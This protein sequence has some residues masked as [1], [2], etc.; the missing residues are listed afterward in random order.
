MLSGG[1]SVQSCTSWR[2]ITSKPGSADCEAMPRTILHPLRFSTD[3]CDAQAALHNVASRSQR[4][5]ALGFPPA[6]AGIPKIIATR[7]DAFASGKVFK[8]EQKSSF[9]ALELPP[10]PN[11]LVMFCYATAA[12]R[13]F[14]ARHATADHCKIPNFDLEVTVRSGRRIWVDLSTLIF[15]DRRT[16]RRLIVHLSR[17]ITERKYSEDLL[18]KMLH[19]SKQIIAVTD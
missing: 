18:H 16:H 1:I 2:E 19:L 14:Y 12:T 11:W 17:D 15:N 13:E 3:S 5:A 7:V 10:T 8:T 6:R 9:V 4:A